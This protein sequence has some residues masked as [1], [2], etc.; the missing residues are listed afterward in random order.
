M[1]TIGSIVIGMKVDTSLL[2]KGMKAASK[3]VDSFVAGFAGGIA[4]LAGAALFGKVADGILE[5]GKQASELNEQI[6][7]SQQVFGDASKTVEA[8]AQAMGDAFGY[9]KSQFIDGASSIGLI[10]KASGLTEKAAADMGSS[11]SKLAA[12]VSS[13]YNVDVEEG[14]AAIRSGLVG[15]AEPMRRFGVLLNEAA[16]SAEA[17]RLG[18]S[19]TG[20]ELTEGQKVQARAS[21]ITKGLADAQGDLARTAGGAANQVRTIWG[22]ITNLSADVGTAIQ[23]AID[24]VLGF[25]N[26][27]LV[28]V[29]GAFQSGKGFLDDYIASLGNLFSSIGDLGSQLLD[30]LSPAITSGQELIGGW[31]RAFVDGV[32][33]AAMVIRNLPDFFEIAGLRIQQFT[34]N[35]I[36]WIGVLPENL[37]IIGEWI[38]TNW[39]QLIMTGLDAVL[40]L[41]INLGTNIRNLGS[42]IIAFLSDP[43]QG[44]QFNFV[45]LLDGFRSTVAELPKL[46]EPELTS[47]QDMIDAKLASIGDRESQRA[48]AAAAETAKQI[49]AAAKKPAELAA[50]PKKQGSEVKFGAAMELG[51]SEAISAINQFRAGSSG[52]NSMKEVAKESKTQ[53]GLLAS[54]DKKLGGA[55]K[56]SEATTVMAF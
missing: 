25:A 15:E 48:I 53:T 34:T 22:R 5:V 50:G 7:K 40:T 30:Y 12:D 38:G 36:E 1:A 17:V 42:A 39:Y 33:T 47:M 2:T 37:A 16:V 43:T 4:S 44:F 41:F 3:Q 55:K 26:G 29:A 8:D 13:F 52:D 31:A 20:K 14:L 54:I 32:N 46:L 45:P 21:L 19:R 10:A 6:S 18:L 56:P 28:K 51:S 35:V 23:P 49:D 27:A 11:F 9:P 24:A